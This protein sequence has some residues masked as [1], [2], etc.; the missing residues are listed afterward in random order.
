MSTLTLWTR[1]DPFADFDSIVRRAFGP[2]AGFTP[3]R[4]NRPRR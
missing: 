4:G 1:R 2:A 3:Q